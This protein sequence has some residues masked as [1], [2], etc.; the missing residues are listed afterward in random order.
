[1]L[2]YSHARRNFIVLSHRARTAPDF[3]LNDLCGAAG[4]WDVLAR[5]IG[6]ALLIS[7]GIRE[8]SA[9]HLLL[10]GEPDPP[11]TVS[12][13]GSRV[14]YLNPDER[15]TAALMKKALEMSIS[16]G[17]IESTPGI[18]VSRMDLSGL[19]DLLKG[20]IV[21]LDEGGIDI[22]CVPDWPMGAPLNFFLSDDREFSDEEKSA[23]EGVSDMT[24]SVG[25]V[26]LQSQQA[27]DAV[28]NHL[29][30]YERG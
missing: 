15:S 3:T 8:D 19:I 5:C 13:L 24:L 23:I 29:D 14:R 20:K 4:R 12:V 25:P 2:P 16:D 7:H 6:S 1:M 9:V 26:V 18:Y 17:P 21:L 28:H 30:R 22:M 11:K 10:S 27:I